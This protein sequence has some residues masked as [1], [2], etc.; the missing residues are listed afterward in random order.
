MSPKVFISYSWSSLGHQAIVG[1]WAEQLMADGVD[2][3]MDI[4]DLKEGH[5]KFA[6]MERMVNDSSIT[7]VLVF[8][9]KI[10]SDKADARKAGV[11]T[12]SQ[13][14]SK[15]IYDKIEQSKFVPIVCEFDS[16]GEPCLPVFLKSR[17]WID[18]STPEASNKNWERLIRFLY[19]KP[20]N[21][22]PTLGKA[23]SYLQADSAPLSPALIKLSALKQAILLGK[24]ALNVY[25]QDFIN[26]CVEFAG[27][28]RFRNGP[29]I[30]S[31]GEKILA[32]YEGLKNIRNHIID[33]VL[34]EA[35]AD[36]SEKF[37]DALLDL[38]E[39]LHELK[40]QAVDVDNAWF[41]AL[42]LCVYEIFLY[43]VAALLKA[44]AF[45]TLHEIFVTSY[46]LPDAERSNEDRFAKFDCFW[47]SSQALQA[48]LAPEGKRFYSAAAELFKRQA[49]RAD[50]PFAAIIEGELLVFMMALTCD[51]QWFPQTL[52]YARYGR[53]FPFF[54]KA[55]QH[56][57][58]QKMATVVGINDAA[59]LR[60]AVIEGYKRL[61]VNSW[62]DFSSITM[63]VLPSMN[64]DMLDT[65]R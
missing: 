26:A 17:I 2:V 40:A 22:K 42:S 56:R 15:E 25:R 36:P 41:D 43:M 5:D 47:S 37:N 31:V 33:W 48:V 10:Y 18:F 12:E 27:A 34:L 52:Y 11:G 54:I 57:H 4:Y 14:I 61:G 62:P 28:L 8:S 32:D 44:N 64:L 53:G 45:A 59:A 6:F 9:D 24:P 49:D 3:V 63:K 39:K 21:E 13:I 16:A 51:V 60:L 1:Q 50:I 23:P 55:A 19:G 38:L 20:L 35:V 30:N 65:L 29:E 58:F 7:Q 46:L